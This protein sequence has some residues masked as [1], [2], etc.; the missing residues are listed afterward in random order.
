MDA[1]ALR[2]RPERLLPTDPGVRA[3]ASQL[4]EAVRDEPIISPRGH[5]EARLL[6]GRVPKSVGH[7]WGMVG[8]SCRVS[9]EVSGR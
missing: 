2:L 7:G 3:I 6:L 4:Y 1:H 8:A 5:V 9:D